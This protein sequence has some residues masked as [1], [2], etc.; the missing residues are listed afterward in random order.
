MSE[1]G[2]PESLSAAGEQP[3]REPG[4]VDNR[5]GD[6]ALGK[7]LDLAVEKSEVEARVV[8]DEH[9]VPREREE[10]ADGR[11]DPRRPAQVAVGEARQSRDR[12][13]EGPPGST[14]VSNVPAGSSPSIRTAPISQIAER[15]GVRP[16]VSRSTTT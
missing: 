5:R 15:A 13:R 8:R 11:V 1:G 16:V 14:K 7:A 4:G 12:R 6:P 2:E 10:A 3:A 9:G